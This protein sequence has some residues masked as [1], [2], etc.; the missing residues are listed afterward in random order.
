MAFLLSFANNNIKTVY[1]ITATNIA[2]TL[3]IKINGKQRE[4]N[5]RKRP[6]TNYDT[7][8]NDELGNRYTFRME[9]TNDAWKINGKLLPAW[10]ME[11]EGLINDALEKQ[12]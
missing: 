11:S 8:T 12:G 6:D 10:L 1:M 4:F 5:F 3:L 2:F 9:K 7:D